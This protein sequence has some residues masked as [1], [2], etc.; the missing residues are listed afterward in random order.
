MPTKII[1]VISALFSLP[2]A[3]QNTEVQD[4]AKQWTALRDATLSAANAMPP[5]KYD[6]RPSDSGVSFAERLLKMCETVDAHFAAVSHQKSPFTMPEALDAATV[7]K[8]VGD[9]F[10]FGAK[11]IAAVS[12]EDLDHGR[13]EVLAAFAG[14]A[15]GLGEVEA[16][17]KAKDMVTAE[18]ADRRKFLFYGFLAAWLLVC[19]YVVAISLRERRLRGELDRVK[20][21]IENREPGKPEEVRL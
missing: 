8:I 2:A 18:E 14:A 15:V 19:L 4:L 12:P 1:I 16:Y 11:T 20:R 21:L 5:N 13:A 3:A 6:F 9:S 7:K 10:D 17:I